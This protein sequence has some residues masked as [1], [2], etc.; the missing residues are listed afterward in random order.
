MKTLALIMA[1]IFCSTAEAKMRK[2]GKPIVTTARYKNEY[3][4][5]KIY[6]PN[7]VTIVVRLDCTE[8]EIFVS[9]KESSDGI[10]TVSKLPCNVKF[11][12]AQ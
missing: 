10:Y 1:L 5:I 7:R 2:L 3:V 8:E 11:F 9:P 12:D 4:R 6:N